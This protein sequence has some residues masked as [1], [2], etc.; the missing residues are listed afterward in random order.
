MMQRC[1]SY[2]VDP[3]VL[4]S[5]N[6]LTDRRD[7]LLARY[8]LVFSILANNDQFPYRQPEPRSTPGLGKSPV[9]VKVFRSRERSIV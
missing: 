9:S 7:R 3:Y 4:R 5:S 6:K 8:L 2:H 1:L